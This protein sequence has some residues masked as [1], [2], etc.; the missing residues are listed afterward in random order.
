[1]GGVQGEGSQERKEVKALEKEVAPGKKEHQKHCPT[2]GDGEGIEIVH[3]NHS[4]KEGN[5]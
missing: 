1:L 4:T 2:E 3:S 5:K